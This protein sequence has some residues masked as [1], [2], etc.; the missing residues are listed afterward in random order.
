MENVQ[1]IKFS[2]FMDGSWR[3]KRAKKIKEELIDDA[4]RY[5]HYFFIAT[6]GYLVLDFG[7]Y[8]DNSVLIQIANDVTSVLKDVADTNVPLMPLYQ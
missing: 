6:L 3:E 5:I 7:V 4:Q 1:I 2:D 8:G